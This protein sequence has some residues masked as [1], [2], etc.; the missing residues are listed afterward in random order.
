MTTTGRE[1]VLQFRHGIDDSPA[2][3]ALRGAI[4]FH[5]HFGPDTSPRRF[6]AIETA[7]NARDAGMGGIVIKNRSYPT[8]AL[9]TLVQDLVPEVAVFGGVCLEYN[10]GGLN[11]DAVETSARMGGRV[12]WMPVL[13]ARNSIGL[14]RRKLGHDL[15]GEGISIIDDRGTLLPEAAEIL[16][17]VKEHDMV[18]ATGHLSAREITTLADRAVQLG[19]TKMVVTHAMSDYL[20]ESILSPEERVQLARA[21]M[22]IEHTAWQVS[23]VGGKTRPEEVVASIKRE[24]VENCILATDGGGVIHPT[25]T[26]AL[27]MFIAALLRN[28]LTEADVARMVKTN[29]ARLLGMKDPQ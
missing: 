6:N 21:G 3:R 11:V 12:V 9:A 22:L 27:R 25:E 17:A 26:E 1:S 2:G 19:V 18:L 28:G 23:P 8:A 5:V 13:D 16:R 10:V 4:D 15:K 20:S 7:L 24:G 14:V 29:P